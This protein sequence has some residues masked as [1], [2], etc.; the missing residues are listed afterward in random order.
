MKKIAV[1]GFAVCS[2]SAIGSI[3]YSLVYSA[4]A[5]RAADYWQDRARREMSRCDTA[6]TDLQKERANKA[7]EMDRAL[8]TKF[9]I[10]NGYEEK[11]QAERL[12]T[13]EANDRHGQTLDQ[14]RKAV[15]EKLTIDQ[16]ERLIFKGSKDRVDSRYPAD[17]IRDLYRSVDQEKWGEV[18]KKHYSSDLPTVGPNGKPIR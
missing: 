16:L 1:W 10:I 3:V 14:I 9:E 15:A 17:P 12:K 18:L 11:L 13:L 2:I 4:D 7:L 8:S 6:L 5:S